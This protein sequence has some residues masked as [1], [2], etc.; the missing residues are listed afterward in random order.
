[1]GRQ[2]TGIIGAVGVLVGTACPVFAA[3]NPF[4]QQ[5]QLQQARQEQRK[6]MERL[7]NPGERQ[8]DGRPAGTGGKRKESAPGKPPG[9]GNL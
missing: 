7:E 2:W 6:R 3:P 9:P 5:E 4:L 1:M 8:P